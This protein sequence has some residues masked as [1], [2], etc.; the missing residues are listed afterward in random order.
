NAKEVVM[1]ADESKFN[2]TKFYKSG[3]FSD[4]DVLYTNAKL[5]ES[6]QN[7]LTSNGVEV[8]TV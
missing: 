3:S 4:I 5:D 7:M 6:W 2:L 1:M 8:I